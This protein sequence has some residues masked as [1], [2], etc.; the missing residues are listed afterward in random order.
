MLFS[1]TLRSAYSCTG[2]ITEGIC[3]LQ[4]HKSAAGV[5]RSIKTSI[6]ITTFSYLEARCMHARCAS[7]DELQ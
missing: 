6:S 2:G 7:A 4:K 1:S 3:A 5:L